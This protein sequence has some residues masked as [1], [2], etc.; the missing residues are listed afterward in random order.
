MEAKTLPIYNLEGKEVDTFKLHSS[1]FNGVVNSDAIYQAVN[2]YRAN[3]R[4]GLASTKTRGEVSGGGKKPWKQKGTGRAR[5]GSSRSPLWKHGG[6]T[7]GPLPRDFSY[8]IPEKIKRLALISSL[9]AKVRENNFIVLDT[10]KLDKPKVKEAMNIF[11][12]LKLNNKLKKQAK[13]LLLLDKIDLPLRLSLRNIDFLD[14]NLSQ[15]TNAYEVLKSKKI[16]ITK[17]A[18]NK[19]IDR[20][21]R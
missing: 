4:K 16:I 19:L 10:F 8:T 14:F 17:A 3:S 9:N 18:L 20:L 21:K 7:F 6:V 5:V 15:N 13:L 1:V 11:S 12:N 2:L